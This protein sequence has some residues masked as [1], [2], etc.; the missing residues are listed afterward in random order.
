MYSLLVGKAEIPTEISLNV[1]P[2]LSGARKVVI[3]PLANEYPLIHYNWVQDNIKKVDQ[4]SNGRIGYIYIPDMG[5]EG[6]NEFARYFYP[7]LDKEG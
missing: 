4:A 1:K 3:S 6:L 2:Q 5:P 7:Q